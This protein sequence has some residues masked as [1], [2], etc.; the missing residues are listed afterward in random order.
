MET[1]ITQDRLNEIINESIEE[2][3]NEMIDEGLGRAIG[4][5]HQWLRN[6]YRNFLGDMEAGR[7]YERYKN[8]EYDPYEK[9]GEDADKIRSLD[10][11]TYAKSRYDLTVDRNRRA[12]Q[13][14]HPN[15]PMDRTASDSE[16]NDA[17]GDTIYD[18]GDYDPNSD[19]PQ[20]L[21][22]NL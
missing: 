19:Q 4:R 12:R 1:R 10:S 18:G 8:M 2:V 14:Y 6:R 7:R 22:K 15:S 9:Y 20:A 16:N 21:P 11:R 5:A 17:D 13:E 3:V